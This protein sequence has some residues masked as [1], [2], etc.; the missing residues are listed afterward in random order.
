MEMTKWWYV[1]NPHPSAAAP[2]HKHYDKAS[3][4]AEAKRLAS[5]NVGGVFLV[6][7]VV[8]GYHVERPE[9]EEIHM[10]P[11]HPDDIPF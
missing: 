5:C 6:L 7:K 4:M 9:P 2:K 3:A 11:V 8:G 10:V 1:W